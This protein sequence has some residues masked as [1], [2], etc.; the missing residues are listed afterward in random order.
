MHNKVSFLSFV[1]AVFLLGYPFVNLFSDSPA[2]ALLLFSTIV[3][4]SAIYSTGFTRERL[5]VSLSIGVPYVLSVWFYAATN[6][7]LWLYAQTALSGLFYFFVIGSILQHVYSAKKVTSSLL[8]S[9]VNVYA[10]IGIAWT[11]FY[12]AL[13]YFTEGAFMNARSWGDFL[14]YSFVTLTTLGNGDIVPLVPFAKMLTILEAVI[15]VLFIAIL[16][17]H[18][19]GTYS[20]QA[21]SDVV[22]KLPE[23]AKKAAAKPKRKITRKK[24]TTRKATARKKTTTKKAT[25]RKAATRKTTK[26]S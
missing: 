9:A 26:K 18:L 5:E 8:F 11:N 17:S 2:I 13:Q 25:P 20:S 7:E 24:T 1:I 3:P 6:A 14:Y 19:V 16:I 4:L 21:A 10:L 12:Y 15:G 23:E 22:K